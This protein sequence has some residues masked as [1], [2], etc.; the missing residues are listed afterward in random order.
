MKCYVLMEGEYFKRGT[1]P[2][3]DASQEIENKINDICQNWQV[4]DLHQE[5]GYSLYAY[6]EDDNVQSSKRYEPLNPD[7]FVIRGDEVLG[8]FADHF[9]ESGYVVFDGS[10]QVSVC[11]YDWSDYS[12]GSNKVN[13]GHIQIVARPDTDTNPY[14][15][16]PRFHSQEE[17][18]DYIKWRD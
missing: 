14:H 12:G 7:S 18:D 9:G 6:D 5:N 10:K 2:Q 13:R 15:D 16:V 1:T 4:R 11:D 17:Y 3:V 8:Y